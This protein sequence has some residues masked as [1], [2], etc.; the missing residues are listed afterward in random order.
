MGEKDEKLGWVVP[1]T[2]NYVVMR[3][4][5]IPRYLIQY[6]DIPST[7]QTTRSS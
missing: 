5:G 2:H 3:Y 6:S 4:P 1:G 7:T